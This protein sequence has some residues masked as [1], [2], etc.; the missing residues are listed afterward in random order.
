MELIA[1]WEKTVDVADD[2]ALLSNCNGGGMHW[3]HMDV[4]YTL[5]ADAKAEEWCTF[6][7]DLLTTAVQSSRS[8]GGPSGDFCLMSGADDHP[9]ST[10]DAMARFEGDGSPRFDG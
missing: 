6:G 9:H 4:K 8:I 5:R 7:V 2:A 3:G 1:A 10:R